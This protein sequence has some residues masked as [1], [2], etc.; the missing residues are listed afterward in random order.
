[1]GDIELPDALGKARGADNEAALEHHAGVNKGGGI[2]G[3]EDEEI[4]GVAEPVIPGGDPVHDIIGDMIQEN[5]PVRDAAK[6]VKAEVSSFVGQGCVDF[7]G[8]RFE[9]LSRGPRHGQ[10]CHSAA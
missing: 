6:Q 2:A 4:G 3:D 8:S 10:D 5:R 9:L 7:H 1:M